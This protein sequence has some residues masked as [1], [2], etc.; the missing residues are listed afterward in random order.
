MFSDTFTSIIDHSPKKLDSLHNYNAAAN[1][2]TYNLVV[3]ADNPICPSTA[4]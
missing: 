4:V 2:E 1:L 3:A